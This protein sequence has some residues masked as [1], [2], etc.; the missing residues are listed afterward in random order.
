MRLDDIGFY[1]LTDERA[2]TASPITPL[3]RCELLVTDR[4]NFK[5]PYCRGVSTR[6]GYD[7]GWDECREIL[8]QWLSDGLRNIRF[9]GGE[10]TLWPHL[11]R[12]VRYVRPSVERVAISTNGTAKESMYRALVDAGV[13]DF[14]ISLD[15]CCAADGEKMSGGAGRWERVPDTIRLLAGMGVYVTVGVV[16]TDDNLHE[17]HE[18]VAFAQGMGVADVR[19]IPAAQYGATADVGALDAQGLPILE[20]RLGNIAAGRPFRG[21]AD[22]DSCHCWLTLDDMAVNEGQHYPCI[23]YL[24]EGGEPI[25]AVSDQMRT[26]RAIWAQTHNT[27]SDRICRGNC[28]DVCVEYNNRYRELHTPLEG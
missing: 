11:E 14:S 6:R 24:R 7:L 13:D 5:C 21:I 22:T 18:I 4:C 28:L 26:E 27:H 19:I 10:P 12:A 3:S 23:I 15:A 2:R 9:S 8:D 25:G 16:L 1:T 17:T 20:Y